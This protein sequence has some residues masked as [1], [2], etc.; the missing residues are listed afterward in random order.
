MERPRSAA[1]AGETPGL[2]VDQTLATRPKSQH[3]LRHLHHG[4]D[5]RS[6]WYNDIAPGYR[7]SQDNLAVWFHPPSQPL[8]S[9][10]SPF[11]PPSQTLSIASNQA[12]LEVYLGS[13]SISTSISDGAT[14]AANRTSDCSHERMSAGGGLFRGEEHSA[15]MNV[16]S[17]VNR[18]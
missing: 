4:L 5:H 2:D 15:R 8:A 1:V 10:G 13:P 14:S 7:K 11:D 17:R 3:C 6:R 18:V 16:G 12:N 9:G